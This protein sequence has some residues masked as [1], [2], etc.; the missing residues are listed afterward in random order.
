M[1]NTS[2]K[3]T[4]TSRDITSLRSTI[5]WLRANGDLI[6]TDK[7]VDPDLEITGLQKHL[8]GGPPM[9]FENVKSMPHARAITNL[10]SDIEVVD[11][12][13]GRAPDRRAGVAARCLV[14]DAVDLE[15]ADVVG[16]ALNHTVA[17]RDL[18]TGGER[19]HLAGAMLGQGS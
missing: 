2:A 6:E 19:R 16:E 14:R 3:S 8:D 17:A 9:L 5:A 13:V 15:V 11:R 4:A 18:P 7:E 10:F 1:T 12:E